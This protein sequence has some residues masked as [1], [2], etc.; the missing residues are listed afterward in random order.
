M[1]DTIVALSTAI[2]VGAIS[3]IRLSGDDALKIVNSIFKGKD[4]EKVDSHTIN[5]GHII[6]KNEI[7]DEVLVTVMKAPKTYTKEDIV[8]INSHGS[9]A[10]VN[11]ILQILLING[12]RLANKGEFTKRAFLNGRIDLTESEGIL[13]LINSQTELTRKMARP[14]RETPILFGDE[15][16]RFEMQMLNPQQLSS[17]RIA[18][19]QSDYEFLRSRCVNCAF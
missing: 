19:M 5:Y 1:N 18:R 10:V 16:R 6:Y 3:I 17:E 14:I 12:C 15:A 9:V 4:L 13:D 7:I 11:R 8:E 2:G